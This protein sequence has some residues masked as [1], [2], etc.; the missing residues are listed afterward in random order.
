M[1]YKPI[2]PTIVP[3]KYTKTYISPHKIFPGRVHFFEFDDS[4]YDGLPGVQR[5]LFPK[6]QWE[7]GFYK[8]ISRPICGGETGT[9][10]CK[11]FSQSFGVRIS[12]YLQFRL[13]S[14]D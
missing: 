11:L 2:G 6:S 1:N 5:P 4:I 8:P 12:L 13:F 3:F 7:K 9:G 14:V 10:E